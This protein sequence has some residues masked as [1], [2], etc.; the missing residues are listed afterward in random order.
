MIICGLYDIELDTGQV[1]STFIYPKDYWN[2]TL[3]FSPLYKNVSKEGIK[4]W[5]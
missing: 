2:N 1:I 5:Q 4:L 3:I